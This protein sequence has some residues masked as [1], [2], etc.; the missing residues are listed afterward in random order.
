MD[1]LKFAREASVKNII[2]GNGKKSIE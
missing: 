2:H 1:R